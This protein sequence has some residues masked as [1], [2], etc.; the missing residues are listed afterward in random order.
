MYQNLNKMAKETPIPTRKNGSNKL[1]YTYQKRISIDW[2]IPQKQNTGDTAT[3]DIIMIPQA[4]PEEQVSVTS[5]GQEGGQ[6]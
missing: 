5:I 2:K 1:V 6:V 4:L 3:K